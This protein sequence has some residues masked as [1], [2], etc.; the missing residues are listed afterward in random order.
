MNTLTEEK[1]NNRIRSFKLKRGYMVT[2]ANNPG[3][4]GYSRC[5]I[6]DDA[7]L[8]I[9]VLPE[10]LD[11]HISSYRIF[12]WNDTQKKGLASDTGKGNNSMLNSS[13]CYT[14]GVGYD[15]GADYE[16]VPHHI[17]ETYPSPTA[18]GESYIFPHMKTN[19]EPANPND[20]QPASSG[21]S[22]GQLGGT[23]GNGACAFVRRLIMT[24][25]LHGCVIS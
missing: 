11:R 23:H 25:G 8:E 13:W 7:D 9:A 14:W 24:G 5:F 10:V 1:L 17:H 22:V 15:M 3:G 16:C 12:K 21:A 2:F 4:R 19:N 6:A 18:L 20:D